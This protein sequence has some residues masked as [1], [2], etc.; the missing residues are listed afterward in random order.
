MYGLV[1]RAVEDWG[2]PSQGG[3]TW[4]LVRRLAGLLGLGSLEGYPGEITDELAA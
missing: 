4:D 1:K 3:G 2:R